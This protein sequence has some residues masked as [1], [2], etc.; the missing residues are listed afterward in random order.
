MYVFCFVIYESKFKREIEDNMSFQFG[1]LPY[2]YNPFSTSMTTL[3]GAFNDSPVWNLADP[4]VQSQM[5]GPL[6]ANWGEVARNR[7]LMNLGNSFQNNNVNSGNFYNDMLRTQAMMSGGVSRSSGN[8]MMPMMMQMFRM[9]MMMK[10][11]EKTNSVNT[12]SSS[13]SSNSVNDYDDDDDEVVSGGDTDTKPKT[14]DLTDGKHDE[15]DF[16]NFIESEDGTLK[17]NSKFAEQ[18]FAWFV[19]DPA[20]GKVSLNDLLDKFGIADPTDKATIAG[21]LGLKG[22]D[23]LDK[24]QYADLIKKL[25]FSKAKG[26]HKMTQ[27]QLQKNFENLQT[28]EVEPPADQLKKVEESIDL[29]TKE[30]AK[31]GDDVDFNKIK[32]EIADISSNKETLAIFL[33][34]I[35]NLEIQTAENGKPLDL[36]SAITVEAGEADEFT[37]DI[38]AIDWIK[39]NV[40]NPLKSASVNSKDASIIKNYN[41]IMDNSVSPIAIDAVEDEIYGAWDGIQPFGKNDLSEYK[42]MIILGRI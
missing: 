17:Y 22:E 21:K 39:K 36:I 6:F 5:T 16:D 32:R 40:V 29:L 35:K 11:L 19:D 2:G 42:A 25:G 33:D 41:I 1:N 4:Q 31:D 13:Y 37:K 9:M 27:E 8:D 20:S 7:Q 18:S 23:E 24:A 14:Y 15:T 3:G 30:L 26:V 12:T 10:Q 28:I 34:K 38:D